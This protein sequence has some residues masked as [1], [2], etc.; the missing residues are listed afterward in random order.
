MKKL[1]LLLLISFNTYAQ[2]N[3]YTFDMSSFL[4]QMEK[5]W[6]IGNGTNSIT[7]EFEGPYFE[8]VVY[9]GM[10]L[11][12]HHL[13]IMNSKITVYGDT[14]NSYNGITKKYFAIS[15][16]IVEDE[17]LSIPERELFEIKMYPNPA[18][19]YVNFKGNFVERLEIYDIN[20]KSVVKLEPKS[21][22][23]KV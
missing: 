4:S 13:E 5:P 16:L 15:D 7:G 2:E 9:D 10:N 21:N 22:D 12:G 8:V 3:F 6:S 14:I 20:G 11:G 19:G 1:I 18:S 17:V 23:F